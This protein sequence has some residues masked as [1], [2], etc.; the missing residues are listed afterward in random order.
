MNYFLSLQTKIQTLHEAVY[1]SHTTNILRK[2][3]NPTILPFA[4]VEIIFLNDGGLRW[5]EFF[6]FTGDSGL[7]IWPELTPFLTLNWEI[8]NLAFFGEDF[9]G[10]GS[11]KKELRAWL[12]RI[13]WYEET[14]LW[15]GKFLM[16]DWEPDGVLSGIF[17]QLL[18]LLFKRRY[19]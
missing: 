4:I 18:N 1:F 5:W 17:Y 2:G 15:I 14:F 16:A 12:L 8:G 10:S 6:V 13:M 11:L 19:F 3:M 7:V 9:G